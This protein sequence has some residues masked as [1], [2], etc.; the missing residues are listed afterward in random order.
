MFGAMGA[1]PLLQSASQALAAEPNAAGA[2]RLPADHRRRAAAGRA[3]QQAVSKRRAC[4]SRSRACSAAGRRL[5]E[6]FLA[7]QVNVVHL[8]SPMTVWARYGSKSRAKVVAWNH[9]AGSSLTVLPEINS[10]RRSGRQDGGDSVLVLDPQRGAAAPAARPGPGSD[11]RRQPGPEA[12]QAGRD[13]A[14][15]HAAGAGAPSRL[16]AISWPSRSTRWPKR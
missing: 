7:G 4:R 11:R 6:A 14:R 10:L 5:V 3:W 13:G 16:P 2:H 1:L 8:L 15:R 12:G 9:M